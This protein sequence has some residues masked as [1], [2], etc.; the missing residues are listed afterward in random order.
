MAI[1]SPAQLF[2]LELSARYDA[3]RKGNQLLG[4]AADQ[5]QHTEL[6]QIL[7]TEEQTGQRE[8]DNLDSCFQVLGTQRREIPSMAVEGQ[9]ADFQAVTSQQPSTEVLAMYAV[10]TATKLAHLGIASYRELM[11]K[12][13]LMNQ[14]RCA[15][16]LQD[17][18][19]MKEESAGRFERISHEMSKQVLAAG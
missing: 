2:L 9:R 11:D 12:A 3:E 17:N 13:V 10:G 19:V 16:I 15:Q 14:T 18:L 7:R 6:A 4:E 1:S 5:I 8:I